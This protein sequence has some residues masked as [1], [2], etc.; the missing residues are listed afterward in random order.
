MRIRPFSALAVSVLLAPLASAQTPTDGASSPVPIPTVEARPA[1]VVR[2]DEKPASD[3]LSR[4]SGWWR[5]PSPDTP[6]AQTIMAPPDALPL[7]SV[8]RF[9]VTNELLAWAIQGMQVPVLLTTSPGGTPTANAGVLGTPGVVPVFGP[10]EADDSVRLGWRLT[11]GGWFSDDHKLG[12][13]AQFLTMANN[14][15]TFS[16]FSPNG[17]PILARPAVNSVTHANVA[18][19]ISVPGVTSGSI[20]ISAATSGILGGGVLLR[21]NFYDS[22]EPCSTCP[23]GR[24][25]GC[26]P[27]RLHTRFDSL[28]GFRYARMSDHLEIDDNVIAQVALNGLPAGGTLQQIDRFDSHNNFYG[29]DLGVSGETRCGAW[30]L[31]ALAKVAV[32]FNN[33][34]VDIY[35]ANAVNGIPG[36]GGFLAQPT[37]MGHWTRTT[38]S[39]IP[40]IDLKLGYYITPTVQISVGYSF[41]YWYHMARAANQINSEIDPRFLLQGTPGAAATQP[42]FA[43]QERGLWVQGLTVG[44]EWRY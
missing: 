38:V 34:S 3:L 24:A 36:A 28:F 19:P 14:G 4:I 1:T 37:N 23:L 41:L 5:E 43:L 39:A 17:N 42:G 21:E 26:N 32:G 13:E 30:S 44:V 29:L 33:A 8:G 12:I 7:R 11:F 25:E 16:A 18:E 9:W 15:R 35:G 2:P 27:G 6:A 31:G 20:R 40:E 10:T 22:N